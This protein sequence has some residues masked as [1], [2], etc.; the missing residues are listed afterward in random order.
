MN[1]VIPRATLDAIK[2]YLPGKS[3]QDVQAE[4]GLTD[5][6]KLASNENP[7]GSPVSPEELADI[8]REVGFYPH[9][10]SAPLLA[11]LAQK[12]GVSQDQ[13]IVGNGSDEI[14]T[15]IGLAYLNPGDQV[16]TAAGTFSEYGFVAHLMDADLIEIPLTHFTFDL[17]AIAEAITDRT[18]IVFIANPNNPS[19]TIVSQAELC[20]LMERVPSTVLVV[21]DEAYYEFVDRADYPNSIALMQDFPNI[22][23]TRTFSKLYGLAGFRIGYAIARPEVIQIL[24]KVRQPFNVNS[25]A[26]AA[27]SLA[28]GKDA[29]IEQTL[30]NNREQRLAL[31][32]AITELGYPV[33]PSEA[34]FL[35]IWIGNNAADCARYCLE[36][37][38][39]IR[40]LA[41]FGMSEFIRVTIGTPAQNQRFLSVLAQFVVIQS[42]GSPL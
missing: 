13:L 2:P 40:H 28:L 41:S 38:V 42:K 9:L 15:M 25:V 16:L 30:H 27:A 19:G 14:L 23:V 32:S 8:I 24:Y 11:Q 37:G 17:I 1:S 31:T 39:I 33:I 29:F 3:I 21:M 36:Q 12:W 18:K 6:I 35:C 7:F 20:Q 5:V 22:V 10:G 34:N 4:L 26:L